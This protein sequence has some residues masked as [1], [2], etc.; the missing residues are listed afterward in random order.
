MSWGMWLCST[1][2]TTSGTSEDSDSV[3]WLASGVARVKRFRYLQKNEA[4]NVAIVDCLEC[5][6]RVCAG[7]PPQREG[8]SD[9]VIEL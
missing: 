2:S 6:C 4:T 7:T 9:W 8:E 1:Y 3:T 5:V